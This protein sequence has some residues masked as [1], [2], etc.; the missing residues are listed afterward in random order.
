M[1]KEPKPTSNKILDAVAAHIG[2][3]RPYP[4]DSARAN[5]VQYVSTIPD[6]KAAKAALAEA[7]PYLSEL[8]VLL[9]EESK[10]RV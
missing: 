5:K 8:L 3:S 6:A 4:V 9:R 7:M 10:R 1:N 2:L